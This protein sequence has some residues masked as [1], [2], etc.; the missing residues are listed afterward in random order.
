MKWVVLTIIAVLVPYT[1]LTLHYRKPGHAFEPY[2]DLK[3]R[4]NIGRLLAAGYQR[5][6][7]DAARPADTVRVTSTA[8]VFP[9]PGGLP[10]ELDRTLID[11]P[12]LPLDFSRV[13]AAESV[14]T[15]EP[16]AV[17]FACTLPPDHKL[18]L[19]G[20]YLYVREGDLVITP[21]FEKLGGELLART[22]DT[23]ALLT[24]P[25][26]ALKPGRYHVILAGQRASRAWWLQVH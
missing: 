21:D 23:T 7:V 2:H 16:Y 17:E 13:H 6:T 3:N 1:W 14:S 11:K 9:A 15:H 20:A 5:V 4:A 19:A 8:A 12:M 18:Q 10:E 22:D 25:A 26:S 24:I